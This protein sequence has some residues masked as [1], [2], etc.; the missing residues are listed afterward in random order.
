VT[1]QAPPVA[2]QVTRLEPSESYAA[3]DPPAPSLV[4]ESW[5][6]LA[7]LTAAFALSRLGFFLAGVRFDISGIQGG[8]GGSQWQLLDIRLLKD[9]LLQSVWHLHSQPPLYNLFVG[10][11]AKLPFGMQRPV[12]IAC[13]LAM[14]LA[15]VLAT[16]LLL[17][18][19]R[20]PRW[21][22]MTVAFV[23]VADPRYVLYENWLFYAY[24][25]ALLVTVAGLCC[26]RYLRTR[27]WW[28]G[29]GL[30]GSGAGLVLLNSSWQW[31]WLAAVLAVVLVSRRHRWRAVVAV[32]ALPLLL[33]VGWYVK[34]GVMFGTYTTSSWL[35]MNMQSVTLNL[36]S[37][38]QISDLVRRGVLSPIAKASAFGPVSRYQPRFV[39]VPHTGIPALDETTTATG[40]INF[41]YVP[42]SKR[43][44]HDDLAY[45]VAAPG[46]YAGHVV[47]G[48]SAWFVPAD[49]SPFL[50]GNQTHIATYSRVF[51]SAVLWQP[52]SPKW[53][54]VLDWV[55]GRGPSLDQLS[56]LTLIASVVAI[57]GT[58]MVAWRRRDDPALVSTLAFMWLTLAY[59]FLTT[60][61]VDL[62]ENPRFGFELGPLPVVA[63]VA[64]LVSLR[65]SGRG[66][67][68][69]LANNAAA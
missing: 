1:G 29:L 11:L 36:A 41:V 31:V 58:P 57:V 47:E 38:G 54:A 68:R 63:A 35:G 48:A 4:R 65:R 2:E 37:P 9:Q 20:A 7:V 25:T 60:S 15:L 39:H 21:V 28:W 66:A 51:D 42:V 34:N 3:L 22:A 61:L 40:Q 8:Y 26:I 67:R 33:V 13:Y 19:L 12:A 43:Y 62:G 50:N 44:L 52:A 24:P 16:Y 59:A 23:V 49:K 56:Y 10:F 55:S 32:A 46:A 53:Y 17:V 27:T 69:G 18:D 6:S 30:F 5:R 14:G 45:I 64:V